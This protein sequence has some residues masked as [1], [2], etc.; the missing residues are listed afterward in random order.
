MEIGTQ[1]AGHEDW[2]L[3]GLEGLEGLKV[4]KGFQGTKSFEGLESHAVIM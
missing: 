3:I 2:S 4:L 1:E